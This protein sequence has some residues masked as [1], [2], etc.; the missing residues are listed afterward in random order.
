MSKLKNNNGKGNFFQNLLKNRKYRFGGFALLMTALVVAVAVLVNVV[1]GVVE[2]NWALSI[3]L[4]PSQVTDFAQSTVD[5]VA[6]VDEDIVLYL[7]FEDGT[8]T[9]LKVQLE[10]M[11]KKYHAMNGHITYDFI[12]PLTEPTRLA[13]LVD[14]TQVSLPEGSVIVAKADDSKVRSINRTDLY[15]TSYVPDST[16]SW[17]YSY[18]QAFNGE[19]KLTSAIK[20]VS[21]ENTPNV[22]FL[23]GHNEV[24]MDYTTI[25]AGYLEDENYN[26]APLILGGDVTPVAGD[27]IVVTCPQTDLTDAEFEIMSAWLQE[28][29]RLMMSLDNAVDMNDLSNFKALLEI[30]QLSFGDGYVI[31]DGN[32]T[33]RWISSPEVVIP[34]MN[35]E[36]EITA[37]LAAS[38][39]YL[40]VYGGRPINNCD[41]PLSG[42]SYDVLLTSSDGSYVKPNQSETGF[43]DASDALATGSQ[44]LA[45]AAEQIHDVVNP[46]DATRIVLLSSPYF[47]ADTNILTQSYNI[48]FAMSAM[49]WLVNRDV[50]V[51]VRASAILNTTLNI[52]DVGTVVTIGVVCALIPLGVAVAGTIVW[53]RRRRL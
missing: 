53:V 25:F 40:H 47:Y 44:I 5:T 17:G 20:Y 14:T 42:V 8:Q 21:A 30:Y 1:L 27:T 34:S 29:G 39:N 43:G 12:G 2:D 16:S 13:Q 22:Y 51:Y 19:A 28:G 35:A 38:G 26:V 33:D 37:P 48:D 52:P 10:E 6:E 32:A 46:D 9:E 11:A 23:A 31:E 15:T 50:S 18:Q 24:G 4:S 3:D 36:H 7:L 45:Y 49:E 41:I